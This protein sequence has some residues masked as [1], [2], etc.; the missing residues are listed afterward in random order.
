MTGCR[1]VGHS[2]G[3]YDCFWVGKDQGHTL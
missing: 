1:D 2:R 3:R